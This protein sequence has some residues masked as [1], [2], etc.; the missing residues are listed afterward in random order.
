MN[1]N[2]SSSLKS[3]VT[4]KIKSILFSPLL[5][6]TLTLLGSRSEALAMSSQS[7]VSIYSLIFFLFQVL[8]I[9]ARLHAVFKKCIHNNSTSLRHVKN[10]LGK[11]S[12]SSSSNPR[13]LLPWRMRCGFR[14]WKFHKMTSKGLFLQLDTVLKY[15][16]P[17]PKVTPTVVNMSSENYFIIKF[18]N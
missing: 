12:Y 7:L 17:L 10:M 5:S 3:V 2:S 11:M 6:V 16:Y 9:C 13:H 1:I 8:D 14:G 4:G 15:V 18:K